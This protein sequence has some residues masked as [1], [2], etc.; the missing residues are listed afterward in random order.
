MK[1]FRDQAHAIIVPNVDETTDSRVCW[2][3]S[4]LVGRHV[5]VDVGVAA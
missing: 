5:S 1:A 3:L 2:R 4:D